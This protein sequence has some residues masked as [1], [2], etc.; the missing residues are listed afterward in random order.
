MVNSYLIKAKEPLLIDAGMPIGRVDTRNP[1][2][3]FTDGDWEFTIRRPP[4]FDSPATSVYFDTKTKVLF[5]ADSFGAIIPDVAELA[6]DVPD[7]AFYEDFSIFNRL[8]HPWFA[9]VDQSKFEATV[10]SIRRLEPDIIAGC[11]AP[12]AKGPR[13]EAHLQAMANLPA[14]GPLD[15]PDQA[16]LDGILAAIQGGGD[17][18]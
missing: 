18:H 2:D 17:G 16:A 3:T 6:T 15:L 12:L 7:S 8:N 1:G 10:E 13:M 5:C 11:H 14:Q 9:L 4:L